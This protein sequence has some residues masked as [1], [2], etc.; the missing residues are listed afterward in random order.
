MLHFGRDLVAVF[1][2]SSFSP[3]VEW[4]IPKEIISSK[5]VTER[6]KPYPFKA[7]N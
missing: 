1:S 4:N 6:I 7:K 3:Y 5:D 2:V